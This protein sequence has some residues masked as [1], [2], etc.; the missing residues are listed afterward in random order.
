MQVLRFLLWRL[1]GL[2]A[3]LAGLAMIAWF[4]DGGPGRLLR[5]GA[6]SATLSPASLAGTLAHVAS[7]IGGSILV[8]CIGPAEA[9]TVLALA[10]A[11]VLALV[12][13]D[14]RRRRRYVRLRVDA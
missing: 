7:T 13:A 2:I 14:V 12:R 4:L 8:F 3:T 5:S 6:S 11:C 10:L 9:L 1:L